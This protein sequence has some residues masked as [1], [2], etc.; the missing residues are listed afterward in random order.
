[1]SDAIRVVSTEAGQSI[2][3]L[4]SLGTFIANSGTTNGAYALWIDRPLG[5]GGSVSHVHTREEEFFYVVEGDFSFFSG[6]ET[7]EAHPGAFVGLPKGLGHRFHND[8]ASTAKVLI[9]LIPGG[10]EG[11]F[12]DLGNPYSEPNDASFPPD[13]KRSAEVAARYGQTLLKP[14][15]LGQHP[16]PRTADLPLGFGRSAIFRESGDGDTYAAGGVLFTLKAVAAQTLGAY[17]V[18]EVA[19]APGAAFPAHRH[20]RCAEGL[21]VFEGTLTVEGDGSPTTADADS[22]VTIP[23]GAVH[24]MANTT[25]R[26]IRLLQLS[27]PGG[28]EDFYRSTCRPVHD[29]LTL[30]DLANAPVDT[31]RLAKRGPGFGVEFS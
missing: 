24:S 18:V 20:H 19:L 27:V 9:G 17:S 1:M 3:W 2:H 8:G 29:R 11:F 31:D 12:L 21:Y 26:P 22:F 15:L 7:F 4:G 30:A 14:N 28:I 5:K 23:P 25:D 13:P 6:G 10:G 16:D